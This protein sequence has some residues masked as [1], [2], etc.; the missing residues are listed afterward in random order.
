MN[1]E[2]STTQNQLLVA[3]ERSSVE[4]AGYSEVLQLVPYNL[5]D[6]VMLEYL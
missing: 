3:E 2:C 6:H 5:E 4:F 1:L